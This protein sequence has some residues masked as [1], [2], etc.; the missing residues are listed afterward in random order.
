MLRMELT[1]AQKCPDA[2]IGQ[3][4]ARWEISFVLMNALP[5]AGSRQKNHRSPFGLFSGIVRCDR[6][7]IRWAMVTRA[8]SHETRPISAGLSRCNG[9]A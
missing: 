4:T 1:S 2:E 7:L 5:V 9:S 8:F 6:P 3:L